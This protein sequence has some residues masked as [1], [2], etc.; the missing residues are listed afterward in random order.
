MPNKHDL[1]MVDI[2]LSDP[3]HNPTRCQQNIS[4]VESGVPGSDDSTIKFILSLSIKYVR[5]FS[6]GNFPMI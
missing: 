4:C 6:K 3:K 5:F 1:H 2:F